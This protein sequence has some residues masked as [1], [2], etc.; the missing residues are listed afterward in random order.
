MID[1]YFVL[2]MDNKDKIGLSMEYDKTNPADIERYAQLLVGKCIQDF[3]PAS[4][5]KRLTKNKGIIGITIEKYFFG[6]SPGNSPRPDFEEAGVEL[7]TTGIIKRSGKWTAKERLSLGMIDYNKVCLEQFESSSLMKK[8]SLLLL[9]FYIYRKDKPPNSFVV[10]QSKLF[11]FPKEDL[12]TIKED[13]EKIVSK[14]Q[15]GKAHELSEGDTLFLGACTKGKNSK[16][17]VTQPRSDEPARKRAF[18]LKRQYVDM[19]VSNAI[20]VEPILNE[21]DVSKAAN[22]EDLILEKFTPFFGLSA[23]EIH[24]RVGQNLTKGA[25]GYYSLLTL[26]ML[27]IKSAKASEFEKAEIL[28]RTIRLS[29]SGQPKEAISFPTFKYSEIVQQRWDESDLKKILEQKFLFV[30][31]QFDELNHLIFRRA[32]FWNMPYADRNEAEKTWNETVKRIKSRDAHNL[33]KSSE[34]YNIHVRPHARNSSDTN[35]TP[36]GEKVVKKSF[37]LNKPYIREKIIND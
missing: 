14:I 36:W 8:N 2:F 21:E 26:R 17:L 30:I 4:E 20:G 23:S 18:S 3:F 29:K 27:G 24:R 15:E 7:K 34:T 16:Q 6:I 35:D 31:F 32:F 5:S 19:I 10:K 33:P 22:T 25:K 1:L 37:W 13:W 9:I 12:K 11:R 28:L